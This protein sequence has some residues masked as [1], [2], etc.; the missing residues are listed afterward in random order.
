VPFGITKEMTFYYVMIVSLMKHIKT[1]RIKKM[2]KTDIKY[3]E[4]YFWSKLDKET[5]INI[6]N[7]N[8]DL[9]IGPLDN[10]NFSDVADKVKKS[11]D[12]IIYNTVY[13]DSFCGQIIEKLDDDL[14][15]LDYENIYELDSRSIAEYILGSE[16]KNTLYL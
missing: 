5:K 6:N 3:C 12:E 10:F 2:N 9:Y 7:L 14:S 15:E 11:I 13:Y 16:L 8:N 1:R 4:N